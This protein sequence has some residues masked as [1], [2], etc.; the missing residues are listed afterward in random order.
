M[1][2]DD[3]ATVERRRKRL[4]RRI[5]DLRYDLELADSATRE[6]NRWSERAAELTAAI[7]QARH[8]ATWYLYRPIPSPASCYRHSSVTVERAT[9]S[10]PAEITC[11][12]GTNIPVQRRDSTGLNGA[13]RRRSRCLRRTAGDVDALLPPEV[14]AERAPELREHLAHGLGTLAALVRE[15]ELD[16][17]AASG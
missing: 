17:A 6:P 5:A 3:P 10:E 9:L 4:E 16:P 14:P 15:G 7:E 1:A 8:D 11:V 2:G 12:S 13:T